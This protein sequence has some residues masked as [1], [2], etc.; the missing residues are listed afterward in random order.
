MPPNRILRQYVFHMTTTTW[1]NTLQ[2]SHKSRNDRVAAGPDVCM[3]PLSGLHPSVPTD[4]MNRIDTFAYNAWSH[5][6]IS[7][8]VARTS[9]IYRLFF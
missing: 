2:A 8:E 9:A 6:H 4:W 5:L 3:T 1:D 7:T